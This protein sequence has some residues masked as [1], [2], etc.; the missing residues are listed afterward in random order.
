MKQSLI[1]L[2]LLLAVAGAVFLL[3]RT[4]PSTTAQSQEQ[5]DMPYQ[6]KA[7]EGELEKVADQLRNADICATI[8]AYGVGNEP[9]HEFFSKLK[10]S[11]VK[12]FKINLSEAFGDRKF[13]AFSESVEGATSEL[14]VLIDSKGKQVIDAFMIHNCNTVWVDDV[15]KQPRRFGAGLASGEQLMFELRT[16]GFEKQ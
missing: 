14:L 12:V 15:D 8:L 11:E 3:M 7:R 16:D 5:I 2:L 6:L 10:P 13:F 1:F 9:I 4:I